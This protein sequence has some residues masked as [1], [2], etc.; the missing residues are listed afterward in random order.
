MASAWDRL[1]TDT[2]LTRTRSLDAVVLTWEEASRASTP[3][4]VWLCCVGGGEILRDPVVLIAASL[5]WL[6]A[7]PVASV[8]GCAGCW[9]GRSGGESGGRRVR[10]LDRPD[11]GAGRHGDHHPGY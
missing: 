2:T 10:G 1:P 6:L 5:P 4:S 9:E 3:A 8:L 11:P 7:L